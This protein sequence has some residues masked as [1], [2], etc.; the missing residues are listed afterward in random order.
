MLLPPSE[1]KARGTRGR[2]LALE[3]LSFPELTP[4]R[5]EVARALV[6]TCGR[7]DAVALLGAAPGVADEVAANVDLQSAPTLPAAR[8]Y[9][10][11]LYDAL[12]L[13][14]LDPAAARRATRWLA[15][16]SGLYGVVRLGDRLAPYRL[17]VCARLD[18]LGSGLEA[19]WRAR[20]GPV[21][22]GAAGQGLVLDCRSSSYHPF[23]R[24]SG[25]LAT[26]WVQVRV[27]GASHHAKHTRGLVVRHLCRRGSQARTV[28][29][30]AAEVGE[31]FAVRLHTPE[32]PGRPWI[33]D[34]RPPG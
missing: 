19:Y 13:P 6:R 30:L 4:A 2:V 23:W 17:P 14:G 20:L 31:G 7:P 27:P 3:R 5:A 24:P 28:P 12:D 1:T 16:V 32:R 22:T 26:R 9:T 10:G 25:D 34:V 21:L 33:L 8:L 11:V 18:G 29:A 15:V